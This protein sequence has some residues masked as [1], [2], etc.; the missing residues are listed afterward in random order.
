MGCASSKTDNLFS[1]QVGIPRYLC[2]STRDDA[3]TPSACP[4]RLWRVVRPAGTGHP[5]TAPAVR[6]PARRSLRTS[7][8]RHD[9][10][11]RFVRHQPQS[12]TCRRGEGERPPFD[13]SDVGVCPLCPVGGTPTQ[14]RVLR[15]AVLPSADLMHQVGSGHCG[16]PSWQVSRAP[17]SVQAPCRVSTF[18]SLGRERRRDCRRR[19]TPWGA[20]NEDI[21]VGSLRW[22]LS[23]EVVRVSRILGFETLVSTW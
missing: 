2:G 9:V 21:W 4:A 11:E 8:Q 20:C 6:T 1:C 5:A 15:G 14:R 7:Y 3:R 23:R 19:E 18:S 12:I 17:L 22:L 10:S 16:L 13:T